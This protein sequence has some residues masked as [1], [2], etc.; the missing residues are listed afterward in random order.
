MGNDTDAFLPIVISYVLQ[1]TGIHGYFCDKCPSISM[2]LLRGLS[3]RLYFHPEIFIINPAETLK[4]MLRDPR[5][6]LPGQ[7]GM[8]TLIK[9]ATVI[10]AS[11]NQMA[12][13]PS[14]QP[15]DRYKLHDVFRRNLHEWSDNE[16]RLLK[17]LMDSDQLDDYEKRNLN[18]HLTSRIMPPYL[19]TDLMRDRRNHIANEIGTILKED[20]PSK[21]KGW[22]GGKRRSGARCCS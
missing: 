19:E 22:G 10:E 7:L 16:H 9:A 21:W 13:D 12:S 8:D 6:N 4:T 17:E 20:S 1:G 5:S 11:E 2:D 18:R 14:K 15:E 3:Q